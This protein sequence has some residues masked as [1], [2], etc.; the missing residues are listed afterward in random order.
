LRAK[1]SAAQ[2]DA[3]F[4]FVRHFENQQSLFGNRQ[5]RMDVMLERQWI[6]DCRAIDF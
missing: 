2:R 3:T 4:G 6:D 5:S 1:R